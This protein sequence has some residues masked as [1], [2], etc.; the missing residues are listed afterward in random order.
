V[1]SLFY[2]LSF[3]LGTMHRAPT[4]V[5]PAPHYVIPMKMGIYPI[6]FYLCL[7][8]SVGVLQYAPTNDYSLFT[9]D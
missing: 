5:I 3:T 7:L 9:N 6:L 4:P 8:V 1:P 2:F